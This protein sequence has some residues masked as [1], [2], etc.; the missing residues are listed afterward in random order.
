MVLGYFVDK[1]NRKNILGSIVII[2][3]LA[4]ILTGS[5][6]SLACLIAM[7]V[8]LGMAQ[9]GFMPAIYSLVQ[10]IFPKRM[11]SRANSVI[12]C[13]NYIGYS[14]ARLN[15]LYIAK[16]GWRSAQNNVGYVGVLVGLLVLIFIKEPVRGVE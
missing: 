5:I 15:I 16:Y 10:D 4:S 6:N 14:L 13:G 7:R 11:R 3:S 8:V 1:Y 2:C 9:S 12:S